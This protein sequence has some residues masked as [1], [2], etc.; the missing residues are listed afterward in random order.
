MK[1]ILGLASIFNTF[2]EQ[3]YF[4]YQPKTFAD[5]AAASSNACFGSFVPL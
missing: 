4:Y 3:F 1:Q 2:T 5:L